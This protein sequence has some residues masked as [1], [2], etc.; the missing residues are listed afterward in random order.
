VASVATEEQIRVQNTF[1]SRR[2]LQDIP[3]ETHDE[4]KIQILRL[5]K[6]HSPEVSNDWNHG[7]TQIHENYA[8][9]LLILIFFI[10]FF[11]YATFRSETN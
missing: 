11:H 2:L 9:F 6:R 5:V 7:Q 10:L 3:N 1:S 8:Y 4:G